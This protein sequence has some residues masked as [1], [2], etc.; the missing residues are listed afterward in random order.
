MHVNM[1]LCACCATLLC[2]S[3]RKPLD[4]CSSDVEEEEACTLVHYFLSDTLCGYEDEGSCLTHYSSGK[5]H[6]N[7]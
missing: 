6:M 7:H 5:V 2:I 4:Q 1:C 3:Q